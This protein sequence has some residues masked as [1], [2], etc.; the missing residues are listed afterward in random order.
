M[1][2]EDD[3][4]AE[5]SRAMPGGSTTRP[6]AHIVGVGESRYTRWGKIED[7]TEHALACQPVIAS[8]KHLTGFSLCSNPLTVEQIG[9]SGGPAA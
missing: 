6:R 8:T 2:C 1:G 3:D 7:V 4:A 5:N 9:G